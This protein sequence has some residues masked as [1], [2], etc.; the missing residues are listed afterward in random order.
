MVNSRGLACS[1]IASPVDVP[2]SLCLPMPPHPL[3]PPSLLPYSFISFLLLSLKKHQLRGLCWAWHP[4]GGSEEVVPAAGHLLI[5]GACSAGPTQRPVRFLHTP[6]T[7]VRS[8]KEWLTTAASLAV[9]SMV[10][11]NKG[12]RIGWMKEGLQM[13]QKLYKRWKIFS[14]Y[15]NGI[16]ESKWY[17]VGMGGKKNSVKWY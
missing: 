3:L 11:P 8:K 10:L 16:R 2:V 13:P 17:G 9:W 5:Q 14:L 15:R 12:G 1:C 6:A 7:N 4:L